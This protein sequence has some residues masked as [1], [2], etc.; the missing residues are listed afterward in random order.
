MTPVRRLSS[1]VDEV[2]RKTTWR[3]QALRR[4]HRRT[5]KAEAL[6][7][8]VYFG[9]SD[10]R[11]VKRALF[12]L[13]EGATS[14]D[15]ASRACRFGRLAGPHRPSLAS[16]GARRWKRPRQRLRMLE[17]RPRQ[18]S[19]AGERPPD[20]DRRRVGALFE[21][22][23]GAFTVPGDPE[24]SLAFE[25]VLKIAAEHGYSGWLAIEAEQ[26]SAVREPFRYQDM[27]LKALRAMA[28]ATG[29]D[30]ARTPA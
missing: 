9:G 2:G 7:A 10:T 20:H 26:D 3:S 11:R 1:S 24:G 28:R 29:L 13:F 6:I 15:A 16:C 18:R 23:R 21:R 19:R 12:S 4:C 30:A 8:A 17:H 14:N 25:P 27:G 22:L 5:K